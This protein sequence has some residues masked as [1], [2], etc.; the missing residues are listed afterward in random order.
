MSMVPSPFF[1]DGRNEHGS[2]MMIVEQRDP[3]IQQ[4]QPERRRNRNVRL[5][6]S[7][8]IESFHNQMNHL[9]TLLDEAATP[10]SFMSVKH[11]D[12]H[13]V[14]IRQCCR[15]MQEIFSRQIE[16][17]FI[18]KG[19]F[20]AEESRTEDG[21]SSTFDE[22]TSG[23]SEQDHIR[24]R[25]EMYMFVDDL[26]KLACHEVRWDNTHSRLENTLH[27]LILTAVSTVLPNATS[28]CSLNQVQVSSLLKRVLFLM[29]DII[30]ETLDLNNNISNFTHLEDLK[31][32]ESLVTFITEEI[33][34][35]K[36]QH[37]IDPSEA[38]HVLMIPLELISLSCSTSAHS[39]GEKNQFLK[40]ALPLRASLL[41]ALR[42][43]VDFLL[44]NLKGNI[45]REHERG[46]YPPLALTPSIREW[47]RHHLSGGEIVNFENGT[48]TERKSI[49]TG[50]SQDPRVSSTLYGFRTFETSNA[51][52]VQDE[53]R[54]G[55]QDSKAKLHNDAESLLSLL[56]QYSTSLLEETMQLLQGCRE[57]P[58]DAQQGDSELGIMKE[59]MS[60]EDKNESV[61]DLQTLGRG[62]IESIMQNVHLSTD[63]LLFVDSE[64]AIAADLKTSSAL[65][66]LWTGM[67]NFIID[68]MSDA[69]DSGNMEELQMEATQIFFR[70]TKSYVGVL[71]YSKEVGTMQREDE[72][73]G[74][75]T[76]IFRLVSGPNGKLWNEEGKDWVALLLEK[77]S[78]QPNLRRVLYAALLSLATYPDEDPLDEEN[79]SMY[80]SLLGL[81]GLD[82][83][84]ESD[85]TTEEDLEGDPW[86]LFVRD[87]FFP[88]L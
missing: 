86:K 19:L 32:L 64:K 3:T 57:T 51:V 6:I 24:H 46:S 80:S 65:G 37:I 39:S 72:V 33:T 62:Q 53:E 14:E 45:A 71:L 22:I 44:Q 21:R 5:N 52:N 20:H 28:I 29:Q 47:L 16:L 10:E 7:A 34:F 56:D 40:G 8:M 48:Q 31:L 43:L 26:V 25:E 77:Y 27:S 59:G 4:Q 78:D 11:F 81:A 60:S 41:Y 68:N 66:T 63:L 83:C 73:T 30:E 84:H 82:S 23:A 2:E 9:S 15:T 35:E 38:I 67:A 49:P 36:L 17:E 42:V 76:V 79:D 55:S 61:M 58:S 85:C 1:T 74:L 13:A 54:H 87:I 88:A 18:W 70:L 50:D 69:E 75:A 12:R